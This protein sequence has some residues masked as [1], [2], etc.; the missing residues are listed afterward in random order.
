MKRMHWMTIALVVLV[1]AG[2]AGSK[3]SDEESAADPFPD[4]RFLTAEAAGA[5]EGEAK[6]AA[7]AELAAIFESR[8]YARTIQQATSWMGEGL[9]EQFDKQVEQTVRIHTDVQLEGARIGRV[10]PDEAAGGFRALA[11]LDRRP[12]A[13]RWQRELAETQMAVDGQVEALHAVQGR[14]SRLAALNGI[15]ALMVRQAAIESRLSVLGRPATPGVDD[16]S[17]II[18]ERERLAREVSLF[19]QLEGNP[20]PPF[21]RRLNAVL[22]SDGYT[23]T[24][25]RDEAA[26]LITGTI[27]VQPLDLGNP[28]VRFIRAMADVQL[29]DMDTDVQIAAFDESL[30]K[31]HVDEGE[32]A[33]RSV[34]GVAVQVAKKLV[35]SL[36]TL[37]LAQ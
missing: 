2:C 16:R 6:R 1:A 15:T 11:V 25:Y 34:D 29:V 27:S 4:K 30:R 23:L 21:T 19:I 10:W 12:A 33:R 5:T 8:V 35:R 14:L 36:G 17:G 3:L 28:D 18:V 26:G 9:P 37:G 32:A 13:S 20:A 22:S 31:G 7:M 24:P